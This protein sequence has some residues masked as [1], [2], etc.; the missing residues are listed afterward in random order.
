M[1]LQACMYVCVMRLGTAYTNAQITVLY[2]YDL[3]LYLN[4]QIS[5]RE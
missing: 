3:S 2:T 5:T 1:C 4:L